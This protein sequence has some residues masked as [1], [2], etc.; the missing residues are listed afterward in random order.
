MSLENWSNKS[1]N[2]FA[3]FFIFFY[4]QKPLVDLKMWETDNILFLA[5][6]K[7]PNSA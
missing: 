7:D 6:V 4:Q 1:M 2:K 3:L 5:H